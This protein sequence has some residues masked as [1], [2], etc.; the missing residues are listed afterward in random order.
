MN[1]RGL[2]LLVASNELAHPYA[3]PILHILNP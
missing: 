2:L 1:S 3:D